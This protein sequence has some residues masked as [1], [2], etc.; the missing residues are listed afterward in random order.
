MFGALL[1]AA[2]TLASPSPLPVIITTKSSPICQALRE[3][4]APAITRA[5]Y[6]DQLMARQRPFGNDPQHGATISALAL[7][8]IKLGE[9]LNPDTF[10][11]SDNPK[12]KAQMESLREKLQKVSDDENNALNV[13]SGAYYTE[14]FEALAGN[15]PHIT[16]DRPPGAGK[17]RLKPGG[18][19]LIVRAAGALEEEY[20][21]RQAL[22]QRDELAVAPMVQPLIAQ[23]KEPNASP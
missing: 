19:P 13:L 22:T 15:N 11:A 3:K 8:W 1:V 23:C 14:A 5:F 4:I 17:A 7:N 20:L 2:V 21:R 6:E 16:F 9:L 10:F 12:D 18:E